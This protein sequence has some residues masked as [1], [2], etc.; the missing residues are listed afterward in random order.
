ME[1]KVTMENEDVVTIDLVALFYLFRQK[2]LQI[3][4][5]MLVGALLM[6][7]YTYYFV[8]PTYQATSSLYIVSASNDSVVNLSDL[9]IG[10]SLTADYEQLVLS[11]PMLESAVKNLNLDKEGIS[12]GV[13]RGMISVSNPSNTRIL[14]ITITSLKPELAMNIANEMAKLSVTWLPEVMEC[15]T[16]NIAEEAILPTGQSSPNLTRNVIFGALVAAVLY[17]GLITVQFVMDDTIHSEDDLERIFNLQPL[18]VLPEER[19]AANE[20]KTNKQQKTKGGA[21]A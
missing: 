4:L 2:L 20:K 6:G 8:A 14:K 9:Q 17:C 15:N 21:K 5:V 1:N 16:P 3:V 12:P 11:R 10:S 18:A 7:T 13:L 19:V